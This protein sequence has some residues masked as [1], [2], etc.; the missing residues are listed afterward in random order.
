MK[1]RIALVTLLGLA[2]AG[3]LL[4]SVG[5]RA[6]LTAATSVGWGGFAILC[7]CALLLFQLLGTAWYTLLPRSY[8]LGVSVFIWARMVRDS[9]SEALPFSQVGG[10]ALGVRAAILGGVGSPVAVASMVVDVTTEMLAQIAYVGVGILILSARAP[11]TPLARSLTTIFSIGLLLA[12]AGGGIFLTLQ[13]YGH[14]WVARQIAGRLSASSGAFTATAAA[15]L[16]TI[17]RSRSRI[18]LSI[19]LHLLGW[20]GAAACT[21]LALRLIGAR[22]DF[23]SVVAMESLVY[24]ARSA[25]FI[26]PNAL[27]VQE[28]AYAVLAPLV[29]IS[30]QVGLAVSLIRR[31]RDIA[32]GIP[33]LIAWQL[34][35]GR[36]A[37]ARTSAGS[38]VTAHRDR[39]GAAVGEGDKEE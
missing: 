10:M 32:V 9:A 13:R 7:L 4:S 27:G 37:L 2:L 35:E 11:A 3:Y 16:D 18:G 26:V 1:L 38:P 30:E 36:Q 22:V 15:T 19:A 20:V 39:S 8:A 17:Y 5:L 23:P 28:G 29:G 12:A 31:A 33:I 24:A 14:H 21:W 25:A 34:L 6:V